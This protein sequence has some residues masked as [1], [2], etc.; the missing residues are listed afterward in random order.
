MK[1]ISGRVRVH[2]FICTRT[3]EAQHDIAQRFC[4]H[5]DRPGHAQFRLHPN[6]RRVGIDARH[7][8]CDRAHANAV[9]VAFGFL[10][11]EGNGVA[12]RGSIYVVRAFGVHEGDG[13]PHR[14]GEFAGREKEIGQIDRGICFALRLGNHG[15]QAG[16][17]EEEGKVFF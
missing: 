8:E 1:S 7:V 3:P 14:N 5:N 10:K 13:L 2:V 16:D 9:D 6:G 4:I 12:L 17:D 15:I 11:K